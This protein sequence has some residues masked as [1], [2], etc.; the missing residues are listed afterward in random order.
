LKRFGMTFLG[1]KGAEIDKKEKIN[2]YLIAPD[3]LM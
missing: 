3:M 1:K 2:Y